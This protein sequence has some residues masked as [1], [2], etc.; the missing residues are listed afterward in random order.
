MSS[1]AL[2]GKAASLSIAS[3]STKIDLVVG[4]ATVMPM[5]VWRT[6]GSEHVDGLRGANAGPWRANTT[7][8][9]ASMLVAGLS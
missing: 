3:S 8:A 2:M 6:A 5:A 7:V 9:I 4:S 1:S